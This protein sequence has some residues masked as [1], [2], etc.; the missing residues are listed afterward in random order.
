MF[1]DHTLPKPL[2]QAPEE[3]DVI[4]RMETRH[5]S[6]L[7]RWGAPGFG[8]RLYKHSAPY[9]AKRTIGW[10]RFTGSSYRLPNL[11]TL[12]AFS[13]HRIAD[14]ALKGFGKFRHV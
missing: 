11:A 3:R 6:L 14:L 4:T 7:R 12:R 8:C 10:P 5:I 9:G 13:H 1:I 2:S